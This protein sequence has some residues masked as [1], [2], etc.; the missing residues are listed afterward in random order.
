MNNGGGED[1]GSLEG[2]RER[3]R[4]GGGPV[5]RQRQTKMEAAA[6]RQRDL[7]SVPSLLPNSPRHLL[8]LYHIHGQLSFVVKAGVELSSTSRKERNIRA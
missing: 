6:F 3:E 2:G 5:E 1:G 7:G 4:K 8:S